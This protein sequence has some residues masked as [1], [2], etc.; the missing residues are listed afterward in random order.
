MA[1]GEEAMF[2]RNS[3]L[4]SFS[5]GPI[6]PGGQA[7][8]YAVEVMGVPRAEIVISHG[9]M[10]NMDE[11]EYLH[12][13]LSHALA[14]EGFKTH[15]FDFRGHGLSDVATDQVTL[16]DM[17]A[18]LEQVVNIST[19]SNLPTI[20]MATSF[21]ALPTLLQLRQSVPPSLAGIIFW[22]P[23]LD[24]AKVFIDPGTDWSAT[25]FASVR[26]RTPKPNETFKL[27]EFNFGSKI[28][29]E[30]QQW[31]S[32]RAEVGVGVTCFHGTEDSLVP[33]DLTKQVFTETFGNDAKWVSV[34]KVGHGFGPAGDSVLASTVTAAVGMIEQAAK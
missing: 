12:L 6:G 31:Q 14:R 22:N 19:M 2:N 23:V 7:I 1:R 8:P 10:G 3:E 30:M 5:S 34:D 17:S 28:T 26:N 24:A 27:D 9:L 21:G 18:E 16:A 33:H 20:L 32:E 25:A 29:Q 15:R 13:R 4:T 11:Y